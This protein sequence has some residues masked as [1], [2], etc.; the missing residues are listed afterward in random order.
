MKNIFKK[1]LAA[2]IL[3]GCSTVILGSVA[4][5]NPTNTPPAPPTQV[6]MPAPD[7][8]VTCPMPPMQNEA[9]NKYCQQLEKDCSWMYRTTRECAARD[10]LAIDKAVSDNKITDKQA[11]KLKK[12]I[13]SFYKECQKQQDKTRKLNKKDARDYKKDNRQYFS[14]RDNFDKISKNTG[15]SVDTLNQIFPKKERGMMFRDDMNQRLTEI[16]NQLVADGKLTQNE[17]DVINKYMQSGRDK[18]MQ[19]NDEQRQAYIEDYK[20]MT[21]EQRLEEIS[22]GTGISTQRLQEIFDIFKEAVKDKI[23]ANLQAPSQP[24]APNQTPNT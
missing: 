8:V 1:K 6:S 12:E 20:K 9:F 17:V 3:A 18:F 7:K 10:Y 23:P 13:N 4:F 16:T 21:P 14:L 2:A 11:T 15:I 22:A 19:M 24:Q 5:A